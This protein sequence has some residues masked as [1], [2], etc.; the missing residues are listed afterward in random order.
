MKIRKNDQVKILRGKDR[1]KT[2]KVLSI[3]TKTNK[4]IVQG[5][6]LFK[7][8]ARP[9]KQGEKGEI[10][11]IAKP[12]P[13]SVVALVCPNCHEA[14]RVGFRFEDDKKV[15]YCKRCKALI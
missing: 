6:N 11:Q 14:S 12:L 9:K 3:D 15:R 5:L 1:D 13:I 7:K 4:L 2:G 10:V 8:H